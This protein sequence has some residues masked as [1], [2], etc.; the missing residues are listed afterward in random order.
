MGRAPTV[1]VTPEDR[2]RF[3]SFLTWALT[4]SGKDVEWLEAEWR[5]GALSKS[6]SPKSAIR[7]YLSGT[8]IPDVYSLDRLGK[9][10]SIP[11]GSLYVA[12]GYI[13]TV[14]GSLAE[15]AKYLESGDWTCEQ[16][17]R[18]A[19]LERIL[20]LF[21]GDDM[22][23]GLN[24]NASLLYIFEKMGRLNIGV[25]NDKTHRLWPFWTWVMPQVIRRG[26]LIHHEQ[27]DA[28]KAL[29]EAADMPSNWAPATNVYRAI[30]AERKFSMADPVSTELMSTF[31]TDE[32]TKLDP[33]LADALETLG[34]KKNR[35]RS[36]R[37]R[38]KIA[39]QLVQEWVGSKYGDPQNIRG[40]LRPCHE[41]IIS[42]EE[43]ALYLGH[44]KLS[45][46]DRKPKPAPPQFE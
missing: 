39:S 14:L 12:A 44:L 6:E 4:L 31:K 23:P 33:L 16:S 22:A 40:R 45:E 30:R 9:I 13:E 15:A 10:L 29:L 34:G 21:P 2:S 17:P 26:D 24:E 28:R 27:P 36:W 35:M 32:G 20:S 8:R 41:R 1:H 5:K 37:E 38:T 11:S 46:E 42:E 25:D 18:H 7:A 19:A 43:E 3:G